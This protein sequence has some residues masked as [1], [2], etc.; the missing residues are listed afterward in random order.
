MAYSKVEPFRL[1][2]PVRS[3]SHNLNEKVF[4][5]LM[6]GR[7]NIYVTGVTKDTFT[8]GCVNAVANIKS[9]SD[10]APIAHVCISNFIMAIN[11]ASV[12]HFSW[13]YGEFPF[14]VYRYFDDKRRINGKHIIMGHVWINEQDIDDITSNQILATKLLYGTLCGEDDINVRK[15]YISGLLHL[16]LDFFDIEFY[17]AAFSNFYRSFENFAAKRVLKTKGLKNELKELQK[18]ITTLGLGSDI[19]EEFTHMY[20]LRC[21][22][23]MHAQK[24]QIDIEL[25]D[26]LKMKAILDA[27]LYK[28]YQPVWEE[29]LKKLR[30]GQDKT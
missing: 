1:E 22:Q 25:D 10:F 9:I 17:K 24:D 6:P 19:V 20:Q 5:S 12:G 4:E 16:D 23:V 30:G 2:C 13:D 8:L 15:E 29:G 27:V 26:V 28:V 3:H 21:N 14:P 7:T 18:I 11:I